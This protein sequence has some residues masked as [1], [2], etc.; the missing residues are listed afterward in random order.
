[1]ELLTVSQV[2]KTFG[3]STRM[4]RYYE[5]AGLIQS[6]RNEENAYRYYN[7]CALNRVQQ[8]T[9][10]RKLQIP[11]K[12][13]SVIL[14]NPDAATAIQIFNENI[15]ALQN[16]IIALDTIKSVLEIFVA[17]I[18]E[19]ATI[20]LDLNILTDESVMELAQTLSLTQKNVIEPP[21]MNMLNKANEVLNKLHG[22]RV[23]YVP[24]MTV[25][26]SHFVGENP[27]QNAAMI[28]KKFVEESNL[29][30]IKPDTR[31]IGFDHPINPY[32]APSGYELWVSIPDDMD[33][34]HPLVKKNFLGGLYA[35]HAI[36][37]GDWDAVLGLQDWVAGSDEYHTD[38]I[39]IRCDPHIEGQSLYLEE[40]LNFF[41]NT[42]NS[43]LDK[44]NIQIDL[45]HP[46][47]PSA[48][49]ETSSKIADS[50]EKCGFKARY[51]TKNKFTVIGFTKIMTGGDNQVHDFWREAKE[52]GRLD[53][54][55]KHRK[56]GAPIY[57]FGSHDLD[58]QKNGGW[59]YTICLVEDD[60]TGIESLKTY[61]CYTKRV[62]ASGWLCFEMT[63]RDIFSFD[64]HSTV[65]KLGYRFNPPISGH[66]DVFPDGDV[67]NNDGIA[68]H[69]FPVIK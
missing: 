59:R 11:V 18:E 64:G 44:S 15:A 41:H 52:D 60:V 30:K 3:I 48:F 14:N 6:I 56:S 7:E 13:I 12:Q 17:K 16:E 26:S 37:N 55:Q 58:S 53:I 33:V 47:S 65:P 2:S 50:I 28:V 9:I 31:C 19:L 21:T 62:D 66:L 67:F 39:S 8:I 36:Q 51:V 10:L 40:Q 38:P 46:I 49:A 43:T 45:L 24:P 20:R 68:Y 22:V 34:P 69:W 5:Q 32:G 57:G 27:N 4:L 35:A 54:L 63:K 1:M 29:L 23:I 61:A 25:A 42:Q